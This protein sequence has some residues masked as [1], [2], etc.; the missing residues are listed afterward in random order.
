MF[1]NATLFNNSNKLMN[2]DCNTQVNA[3][4]F[5]T[6]SKLYENGISYKVN[7]GN[8]VRKDNITS[9]ETPI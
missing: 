4:N 6:G 3:E 9:I 7:P 5:G 2:W 1:N 8:A